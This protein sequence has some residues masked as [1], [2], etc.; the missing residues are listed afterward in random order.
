MTEHS[1]SG[2]ATSP[3]ASGG[4]R[5]PDCSRCFGWAALDEMLLAYSACWSPAPSET[6]TAGTPSR[7]LLAR[8]TSLGGAGRALCFA[9]LS[10]SVRTVSQR[11][12]SPSAALA[13]EGCGGAAARHSHERRAVSP[14]RAG[15]SGH[16]TSCGSHWSGTAAAAAHER[17]SRRRRPLDRAGW[18]SYALGLQG[19]CVLYDTACSSVLSTCHG[20]LRAVQHDE[21]GKALN[22]TRQCQGS[23]VPSPVPELALR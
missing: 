20:A 13:L 19:P 21:C 16:R 18:L 5:L 1:S 10:A 2:R 8:T 11:C 17:C 7:W 22:L 15:S 6:A 4:A 23:P 12:A 3:P 9:L 14:Q